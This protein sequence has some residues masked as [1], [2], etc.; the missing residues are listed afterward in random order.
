MPGFDPQITPSH[1]VGVLPG[2][3]R[4][5]HPQTSFAAI[6]P[7]AEAI[8]AGH[9]LE[10]GL[11]EGSPLA[12]L[13]EL[14]AEVLL[15]GGGHAGNTSLHLAGYRVGG[16]H[17]QQ[18]G[19]A[20]S[21]PTGRRWVGY[22]DVDHHSDVFEA[23]GAAFDAT[24][25]TDAAGSARRI[26]ACCANARRSTSPSSGLSTTAPDH[27]TTTPPAC[28][29]CNRS[30]NPTLAYRRSLTVSVDATAATAV[31]RAGCRALIR[32]QLSTSGRGGRAAAGRTSRSH[33]PGANNS[34]RRLLATKSSGASDPNPPPA[35]YRG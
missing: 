28:V 9:V 32:G 12:R 27:Q 18:T 25:R 6:G 19:A 26:A 31:S 8:T 15:L 5:A 33:L 21:L 20:V 14:D 2:A 30:E 23:I 10:S 34:T 22:D 17:H 11:G 1:G 7:H 3:L 13:Y 4:S 16:P 24:G 29:P 35:R